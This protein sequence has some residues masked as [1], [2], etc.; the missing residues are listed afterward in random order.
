M[1][2]FYYIRV[3]SSIIELLVA[4]IFRKFTVK[5]K[6]EREEDRRKENAEGKQSRSKGEESKSKRAEIYFRMNESLTFAKTIAL[7]KG[8]KKYF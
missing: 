7:L 2:Y 6:K 8:R 5:R 4:I 1:R 3:V